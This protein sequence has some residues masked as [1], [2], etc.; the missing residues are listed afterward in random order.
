MGA[1]RIRR[2]PQFRDQPQDVAEKIPRNGD[3]SHL[4]CDVAAM[5]DDLRADFADLSECRLSTHCG[6]SALFKQQI[7]GAAVENLR[8]AVARVARRHFRAPQSWRRSLSRPLNSSLTRH[9]ASMGEA[10]MLAQKRLEPAFLCIIQ[11][12]VEWLGGIREFFKLDRDCFQ[13]DR[14]RLELFSPFS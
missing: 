7:R 3:L 6:S 2:R 11:T 4:E 14:I 8:H 13:L 12:F 1:H 5:A 10:Y 9:K